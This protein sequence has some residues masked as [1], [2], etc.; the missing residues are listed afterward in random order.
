MV[1]VWKV[2]MVVCQ[3][4]VPVHMAMLGAVCNR[5]V[6]LVLVVRIMNV[7]MVMPHHFVGMFVLM[8]FSQM[9][10]SA[11]CHQGPCQK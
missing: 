9:Q 2:W 8:M 11:Q 3:W 6:M 10:P 5:N 4:L 1:G 7:F